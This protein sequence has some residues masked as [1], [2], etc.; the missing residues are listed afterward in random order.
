[1]V[2]NE[3]TR[4]GVRPMDTTMDA[5][6]RSLSG[7]AQIE[8]VGGFRPKRSAVAIRHSTEIAGMQTDIGTGIGDRDETEDCGGE[9]A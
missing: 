3:S 4:C 7:I 9:A 2:Y 5:L 6:A 8:R 1:M